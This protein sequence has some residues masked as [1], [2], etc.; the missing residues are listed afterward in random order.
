MERRITDYVKETNFGSSTSLEAGNGREGEEEGGKAC[1][2]N[3]R[4][5]SFLVGLGQGLLLQTVNGREGGAG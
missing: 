1:A 2:S 4:F 3:N 5:S